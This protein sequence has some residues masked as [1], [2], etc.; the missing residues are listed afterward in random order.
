MTGGEFV[1]SHG[2]ISQSKSPAVAGELER[3]KK[4]ATGRLTGYVHL[5]AGKSADKMAQLATEAGFLREGEPIDERNISLMLDDE[6]RGKPTFSIKSQ[7]RQYE[8]FERRALK[9]M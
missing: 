2:G 3:V 4:D 7:T 8:E 6:I 1:R 9:A 5:K